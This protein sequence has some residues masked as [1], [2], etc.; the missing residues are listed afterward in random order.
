MKTGF[1]NLMLTL[2]TGLASFLVVPAGKAEEIDLKREGAFGFPQAEAR[3]LCDSADLRVS[4]CSNATYLFVQAVL[5]NDDDD[6]KRKGGDGRELCDSSS[7]VLDVDAD[8]KRTAKIDRSYSLN[9]WPAMPGLH[10]SIVISER[11]STG[12]IPDSDGRGGIQYVQTKEGRVRVDSFMI[13]LMEIDAKVGDTIRLAYHGTSTSPVFDVNSVGYTSAKVYYAYSLPMADFHEYTL[14]DGATF[15]S[16]KVPELRKS[17][18]KVDVRAPQPKPTLTVGS[19]APSLDI[20]HW[21]QD[22]KGKFQPVAKFEAGKIY[23]VEFWAT[24]CGPCIAA[25][26]HIAQLQNDYAEKGVQVV[27]ISDEELETVQKFLDRKLSQ[28]KSTEA[29]TYGELTSQYCLTTDPDRSAHESYMRAAGRNGI[30][31]AFLV[32]KDGLIE[33]IGH[34]V[35]IDQPLESVVAGTW[36]RQ[37]FLREYEES[38]G[39]ARKAGEVMAMLNKNKFEAALELVADLEKDLESPKFKQSARSLAFQVRAS[40][41]QYSVLKKNPKAIGL[42]RELIKDANP[43]TVNQVLWNSI[44]TAAEGRKIDDELVQSA[45]E[46]AEQNVKTVPENAMYLDTLAHL[47]ELNGDLDAAIVT[48]KNALKFVDDKKRDQYSKYLKKLEEKK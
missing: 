15:N 33:W 32:G 5:W 28:G 31:C 18:P 22:G 39:F 23:I 20:E 34:P 24:W 38:E 2:V 12:L 8:Q 35:S 27:S 7:L 26:P 25:M 45:V 6:A 1:R 19:S 48:Q 9:P 4:L 16:D 46:Y 42:L 41:L 11:G 47:Q 30:P 13:P 43:N 29:K 17:R 36:D 40:E 14:K 21:V 3:L 10:Y 44:V 37:L